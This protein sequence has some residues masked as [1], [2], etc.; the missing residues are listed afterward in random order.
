MENKNSYANFF[1]FTNDNQIYHFSVSLE[2]GLIYCKELGEQPFRKIHLEP[3][4][5]VMTEENE[6]FSCSDMTD[7]KI[8]GE[9]LISGVIISKFL[10][11]LCI[12]N[13]ML[14]YTKKSA[15]MFGLDPNFAIENYYVKPN[16]EKRRVLV[17]N[18]IK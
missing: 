3:D 7:K 6:T 8:D 16:M 15:E 11:I 18:K 12:N 10:L 13:G 17:P 14:S 1:A 9:G 5:K 4:F 2:E